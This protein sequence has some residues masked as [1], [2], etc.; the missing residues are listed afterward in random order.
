MFMLLS[1]TFTALVAFEEE[2]FKGSEKNNLLWRPPMRRLFRILF[3]SLLLIDFISDEEGGMYLV[4]NTIGS[5]PE[6]IRRSK[7]LESPH[8]LFDN[9]L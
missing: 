8:L 9:M 4:F 6:L 5:I 2:S 1:F 7:R 3:G